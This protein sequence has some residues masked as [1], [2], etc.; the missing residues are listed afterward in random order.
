MTTSAR[1][2]KR[3]WTAFSKSQALGQ[4]QQ[5]ALPD[6]SLQG[7]SPRRVL[8]L[9]KNNCTGERQPTSEAC[10]EKSA[11][12]TA[13]IRW[14]FLHGPFHVWHGSVP[15][16]Q[17]CPAARELWLVLRWPL[18]SLCLCWCCWR[19]TPPRCD[20][21][22]W[23]FLVAPG[24]TGGGTVHFL[25]PQLHNG[26]P[27]PA[28]AA[29]T[30]LP[31]PASRAWRWGRSAGSGRGCRQDHCRHVGACPG[32][33]CGVA[34]VTRPAGHAAGSNR[35]VNARGRGDSDDEEDDRNLGSYRNGRRSIS[36]EDDAVLAP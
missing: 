20:G 1:K 13:G 2:P 12:T 16:S 33:K 24:E 17:L 36:D 35:Y 11:A 34:A 18:S 28:A 19:A 7:R 3:A 15:H 26:V 31:T 4:G 32:C 10:S 6:P 8:W 9:P 23:M 22:A 27:C 30:Q 25:E 29:G 14:C 21:G 5:A